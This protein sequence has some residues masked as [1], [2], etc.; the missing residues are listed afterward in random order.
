MALRVASAHANKIR[1]NGRCMPSSDRST[2]NAPGSGC[3]RTRFHFHYTHLVARIALRA[4][5]DL[6]NKEMLFT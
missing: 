6:A 3:G 5:I 4:K 1:S 2:P